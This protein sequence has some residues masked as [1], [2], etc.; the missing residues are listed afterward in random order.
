MKFTIFSFLFFNLVVVDAQPLEG[1]C[2]DQNGRYFCCSR[3]GEEIELIFP[4]ML[5]EEYS[6][7]NVTKYCVKRYGP[8]IKM[9]PRIDEEVPDY[10]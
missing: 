1:V 3:G 10:R 4:E 8:A 7:E 9:A 6:Y 5:S 2:T